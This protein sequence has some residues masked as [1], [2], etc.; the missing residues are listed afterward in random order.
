MKQLLI[1]INPVQLIALHDF[2]RSD[3]RVIRQAQD[4]PQGENLCCKHVKKMLWFSYPAI[5]IIRLNINYCF[6]CGRPLM[7]EQNGLD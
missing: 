6:V 2:T 7:R 1:P 3:R 4:S 5:G